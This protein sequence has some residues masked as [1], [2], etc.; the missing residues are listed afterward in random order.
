[1]ADFKVIVFS[2]NR[3]YQ[4]TALLESASQFGRIDLE[5]IAVIHRYDEKYYP[6]LQTVASEFPTATFIQ[7][8]TW[9]NCLLETIEQCGQTMAFATDDSV[10]TREC[11]WRMCEDILL[12]EEQ[13]LAFCHRYGLHLD[14]C[15]VQE[16]PVS[17]PDGTLCN[18]VFFWEWATS[19]QMWN[20]IGSVD[21][22]Q[23]RTSDV[24]RWVAGSRSP[25]TLE[26]CLHMS[27]KAAHPIAAC[28]PVACYLT[29]PANRVQSDQLNR[30]FGDSIEVFYH[31]YQR[32]E[33]PT[34][35][36]V[37]RILNHSTHEIIRI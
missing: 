7:Q 20:F 17:S 6:G 24:F 37:R 27:D 23:F 29:I 19:G 12:K 18:G 30:T 22:H 21:A 10:F 1:M 4:L 9:E 13:I 28:F 14:Y 32:G 35:E 11:R 2:R 26:E 33:R 8:T 15:N 36:R 16:R 5:A 31:R 25:N 34:F 3:P